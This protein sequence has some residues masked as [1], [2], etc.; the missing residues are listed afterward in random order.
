MLEDEAMDPVAEVTVAVVTSESAVVYVESV[1]ILGS[2]VPDVV[3]GDS[4]DVVD[5]RIINKPFGA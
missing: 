3:S 5:L 2:R 4:V 1:E